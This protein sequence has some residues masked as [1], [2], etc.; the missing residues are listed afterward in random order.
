MRIIIFGSCYQNSNPEA[1][2]N[3]FTELFR[4]GV[5]SVVERSFYNYMTDTMGFK[6]AIGEVLEADSPLPPVDAVISVGGDGTFLRTAG[7]VAPHD[8]PIL[9]INTGALGY[10]ADVTPQEIPSA[11]MDLLSG[12]LVEEVRSQLTVRTS[13]NTL[14]YA[15]FALNE[16]AILK[17]DTASM[18]T[19]YTSLNNNFL[20]TYQSDGLIV[21]TPTGSTAYNLSVGGPILAPQ[22]Q[23]FVVTP[24]AA[25]SLTMRPLVITDSSEISV[26]VESRSS[27]YR[28]SCDGKSVI[29]P[30]DS[31]IYIKKAP[32]CV[33]ILK[34]REHSFAA[35]LR[36]KLM[37]GVNP[38]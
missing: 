18:I 35:T 23:S 34:Q 26:K 1:I 5:E 22:S 2:H 24:I 25:H 36:S 30:A 20:A 37:W 19:L 15:T 32:V 14:N 8:I 11:I 6:P 38:R 4:H 10:L 33:H 7:R 29:L 21:A 31:E 12:N 27:S 13:C 9:G 17:A 16:I 28:L 3:L